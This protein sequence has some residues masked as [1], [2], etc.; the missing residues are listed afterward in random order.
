MRRILFLILLSGCAVG[1]KFSGEEL[2][3]M[4]EAR[5]CLVA[6]GPRSHP[7]DAQRAGEAIKARKVQCD[8][9]AVLRYIEAD[10]GRRAA[11]DRAVTDAIRDYGAARARATQPAAAPV[12]CTTFQ[13]GP[14]TRTTCY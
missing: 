3:A 10:E 8:Q 4:P 14:Y 7:Y 11:S 2:Q 1:P 6:I 13:D 9:G 12:T 5:L